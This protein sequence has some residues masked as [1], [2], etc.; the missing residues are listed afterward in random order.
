M[1]IMEELLNKIATEITTAKNKPLLK[2]RIGLEYA[3]GQQKLS[4]KEHS[5]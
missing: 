4:E 2:S 5:N 3:Y 1:P